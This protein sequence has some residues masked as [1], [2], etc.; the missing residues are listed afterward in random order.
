MFLLD[1]SAVDLDVLVRADLLKFLSNECEERDATRC[2]EMHIKDESLRNTKF[3][4]RFSVK[5]DVKLRAAQSDPRNLP[6]INGKLEESSFQ[7]ISWIVDSYFVEK[8]IAVG[9]RE[10][11]SAENWKMKEKNLPSKCL[12]RCKE[13][14]VLL[15]S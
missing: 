10:G 4:P 6:Y 15:N 9:R 14:T 5:F 2:K 12:R 13:L 11:H 3:L 7:N 8:V 1:E